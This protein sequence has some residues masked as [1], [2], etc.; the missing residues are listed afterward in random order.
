MAGCKESFDRL[1]GCAKKCLRNSEG[2]SEDDCRYWINYEEENNCSLISIQENGR[3]TLN[4]VSQRLG[5]SVVRVFQIEKKAM[6]KI[7][8]QLI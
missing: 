4:E 8:K 1:P 5:T 6:A 7:K 2:C 3:M